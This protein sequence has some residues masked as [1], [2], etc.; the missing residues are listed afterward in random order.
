VFSHTRLNPSTKV[1]DEASPLTYVHIFMYC[2][3]NFDI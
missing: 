3:Y 2:L 1:E